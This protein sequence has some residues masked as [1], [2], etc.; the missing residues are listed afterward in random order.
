MV[1]GALCLLRG[2]AAEGVDWQADAVGEAAESVPAEWLCAGVFGGWQHWREQGQVGAEGFGAAQFR[3]R[4]AGCAEQVAGWNGARREI[5]Q[6]PAGGVE[7]AVGPG[8]V[9]VFR[10]VVEEQPGWACGGEFERGEFERG[11]KPVSV[12]LRWQLVLAHLHEFAARLDAV[13]H[14]LQEFPLAGAFR[15][16]R[17]GARQ[18]QQPDDSGVGGGKVGFAQFVPRPPSDGLSFG[19]DKCSGIVSGGGRPS[20]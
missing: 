4:V 12:R 15:R 6:H 11:E 19:A 14:Q 18:S 10:G 2:Q 8:R 9:E 20:S 17:D 1:A 5:F 7:T 16:D 13:P 3:Q